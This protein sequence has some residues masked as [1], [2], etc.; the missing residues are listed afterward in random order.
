MSYYRSSNKIDV[1]QEIKKLEED[2]DKKIIKLFT[3]KNKILIDQLIKSLGKINTKIINEII[4]K[5]KTNKGKT[6]EKCNINIGKLRNEI[7]S[8]I[9]DDFKKFNKIKLLI[10]DSKNNDEINKNIIRNYQSNKDS[11]RYSRYESSSV[12]SDNY[13]R[14]V[15]G[16]IL[17]DNIE[18]ILDELILE[19]KKKIKRDSELR[20]IMSRTTINYI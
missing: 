20:S 2:R 5:I 1:K 19:L 14:K 8:K 7:K 11:Y 16:Y 10:V 4:S 6:I 18:K 17:E 12:S 13:N 3:D 9:G 15:V